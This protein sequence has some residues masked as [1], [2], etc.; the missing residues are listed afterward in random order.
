M[1]KRLAIFFVSL[2]LIF[3]AGCGSDQLK[4]DL[5]TPKTY[6]PGQVSPIKIQVSDNEGERRFKG[7]KVSV[8]F[9][10][11]GM[12]MEQG[13]VSMAAKEIGDGLYIG[14]ANLQMEGDYTRGR[15]QSGPKWRRDMN[16]KSDFLL[17]EKIRKS[18]TC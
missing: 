1:M 3:I 5:I 18:Q 15:N 2:M 7:A 9:N 11:Q 12:S 10:M 17:L 8:E 13:N 6:T 16:K 4:V 14:N